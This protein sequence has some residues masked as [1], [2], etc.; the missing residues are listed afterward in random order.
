MKVKNVITLQGWIHTV[1]V[2]RT[3][4]NTVMLNLF[5]IIAGFGILQSQVLPISV[6]SKEKSKHYRREQYYGWVA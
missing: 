3:T 1:A 2:A 5:W 4:V 6:R